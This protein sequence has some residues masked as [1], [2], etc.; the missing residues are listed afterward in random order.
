MKQD[1]SLVLPVEAR[2]LIGGR[3]CYWLQ[4]PRGVGSTQDPDGAE[5]LVKSEFLVT[6]EEAPGGW[7]GVR[8]AGLGTPS[9]FGSRP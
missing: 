6:P 5:G 8:G 3:G 9:K 7:W 1:Q 2:G 4:S